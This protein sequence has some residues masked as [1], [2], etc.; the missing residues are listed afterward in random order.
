VDAV[1]SGLVLNFV[2]LPVTALE[3]AR[4]V[5]R[6][7]GVV[8]GYVWDYAEG[9]GILRAFWDAALLVDPEAA[10]AAEGVRFPLCRP[11]PLQHTMAAAG[12]G[13]PEVRPL[14]ATARF[15]SFDAFWNPFLG[16]EGPAGSYLRRLPAPA[17][18]LLRERLRGRLPIAAD[19]S[20][21]LPLR[22]WAFWGHA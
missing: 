9:M 14:E 3:E 11:G 7:G 13:D 22:A 8:G 16:G 6:P 1:V 20:I 5:V 15:E 17:R 2:P 19:G 4:R 10:D 18:E 21:V 12:L